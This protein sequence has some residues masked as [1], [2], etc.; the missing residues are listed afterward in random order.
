M[1]VEQLKSRILEFRNHLKR[2]GRCDESPDIAAA[3]TR[4]GDFLELLLGWYVN[5]LV[6]SEN[7]LQTLSRDVRLMEERDAV[8]GVLNDRAR[9]ASWQIR[10]LCGGAWVPW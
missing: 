2:R 4:T 7:H 9:L 8:K 6:M 3:A 5:V 10:P 1:G